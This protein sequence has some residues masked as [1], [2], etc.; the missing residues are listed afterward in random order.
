M[1]TIGFCLDS[2]VFV[3]LPSDASPFWCQTATSLNTFDQWNPFLKR[4]NTHFPRPW[5]LPWPTSRS[6]NRSRQIW[7]FVPCRSSVAP[8][9]NSAANFLANL[10]TAEAALA[11]EW[12]TDIDLSYLLTY[13]SIYLS[14]YRSIQR[15]VVGKCVHVAPAHVK[16]ENALCHIHVQ[17][18]IQKN[19]M[20]IYIYLFIYAIIYIYIYMH[21]NTL[22][23][24]VFLTL[25]PHPLEHP[26]QQPLVFRPCPM[27]SACAAT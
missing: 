15:H 3:T 13:P 24:Q 2:P 23:N 10:G 1:K 16:S 11:S 20:Y 17:I 27:T 21:T 22:C 26:N 6:S 12:Q 19:G 14:I 4:F 8:P 5:R 9:W 18:Y 25:Y 7:P